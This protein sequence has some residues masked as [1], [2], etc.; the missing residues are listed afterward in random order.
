MRKGFTVMCKVNTLLKNRTE[1]NRTEQNRTEQNRT[2]Q[3]RTEHSIA[4]TN[5]ALFAPCDCEALETEYYICDG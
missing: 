5:C 2:E 3:N 4:W 1:Q